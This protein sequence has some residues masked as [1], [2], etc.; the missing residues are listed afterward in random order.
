MP[1]TYRPPGIS[2]RMDGWI[3]MGRWIDEWVSRWTDLDG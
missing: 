3:W 2:W 1:G